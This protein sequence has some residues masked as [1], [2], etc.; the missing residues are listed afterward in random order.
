MQ[1]QNESLR[2]VDTDE[3]PVSP[4]SVN[5]E[6]NINR[7]TA[8]SEISEVSETVASVGTGNYLSDQ[9][10]ELHDSE[11]PEPEIPEE[12]YRNYGAVDFLK[13]SAEFL[14]AEDIAPLNGHIRALRESFREF[15][16]GE[17][18]SALARFLEMED[19]QQE[20]FVFQPSAI[21]EE[22]QVIITK[23]DE[24]RAE[25]KRR[26]EKEQQKNTEVKKEILSQLRHL[27]EGLDS[28]NSDLS[29]TKTY[30]EQVHALQQKWRD[31]GAA[32]PAE[33]RQI[34]QLYKFYLD[35]FYEFVKM[36]NMLRDLDAKKNLEIKTELC[37][38]AE[39]LEKEEDLKKSMDQFRNLQRQWKETGPVAKELADDLWTR[40]KNS[41]D[42][43]FGRFKGMMEDNQSKMQENLAKKTVLLQ[44]MKELN[45]QELP[46]NHADW[47]KLNEAVEALMEEWKKAGFGPK[48]ENEEIWETFR[49]EREI[50]F[51]AKENFYD[52]QKKVMQENIRIKNEIIA[53]AEALKDS[54]EWKKAADTLKRL[55]EEWKKT[56]PV[57]FKHTEKMWARFRSAC[58]TFFESRK[59]HFAEKDQSQ[60]ENLKIKKDLLARVESYSP[61]TDSA[62]AIEELKKFQDDWYAI[63]LVPFREK[64]SINKAFKKAL[65]KHYDALRANRNEQHRQYHSQRYESMLSTPGAKDKAN[66]EIYHLQ[67]RI[68][69]K[70]SE[71]ALL[72][73]NLGFF[74]KSKNA[75][76]LRK[77]TEKKIAILRDDI[78]KMKEQV[79]L[80]REM[81]KPKD[82]KAG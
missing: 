19:K 59:A 39:S 61:N 18:N 32:D 60:E 52:H 29:K 43:I 50:F 56:G 13:K 16:K 37:L 62:I 11:I 63:G 80:L 36:I 12:V 40:F 79:K 9:E 8:E 20:D 4:V 71:A 38:K 70:E 48:K 2:P 57:P 26:R 3:N 68:R 44:R 6:N 78:K 69:K 35:K 33:T 46:G 82:E 49:G 31:T 15:L 51:K 27:V 1:E 73:N 65:D 17:K 72:D 66:D 23:L 53:Q 22:I 55:Q 25:L 14:A 58:D 77:D 7:E 81:M 42:Q 41:G 47:Q 21:V 34:G 76:E 54:T 10:T 74:A 28:G 5:P 45:A 75:D 67:E 30:F 24:R 64:E